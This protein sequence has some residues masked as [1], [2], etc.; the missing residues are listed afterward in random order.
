VSNPKNPSL[1]AL[2]A[3]PAEQIPAVLLRLA[4]Q[5]MATPV[6]TQHGPHGKAADELLNPEQAAKLLRVS[7]KY[8]YRHARELG[9]IRLGGGSRGRLRFSAAKLARVTQ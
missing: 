3:I 2:E 7:K 5:I 9:A 6:P 4:A 8:I 1:D